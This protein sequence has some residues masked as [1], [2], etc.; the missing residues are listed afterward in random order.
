[1][2]DQTLTTSKLFS[3]HYH[4]NVASNITSTTYN[5]VKLC[6]FRNNGK[7]K[8]YL[9][10]IGI[11]LSFVLFLG[12]VNLAL[13]AG[14]VGRLD[15]RLERDVGKGLDHGELLAVILG[16]LGVAGS[17]QHDHV[18]T[19]LLGSLGLCTNETSRTQ[20]KANV[21]KTTSQPHREPNPQLTGDDVGQE[22]GLLGGG[23]DVLQDRLVAV[24]LGLG[25]D[26]GVV[27]AGQILYQIALL[28]VLEQHLL[29]VHAAARVDVDLATALGPLLQRLRD[30][31]VDATQ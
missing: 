24:L 14:T 2:T 1:M 18:Q 26:L 11:Y 27:V 3:Y 29:G 19:S 17:L 9:V 13:G 15:D 30:V 31:I 4:L 25:A 20:T 21:R 28:A 10:L 12:L 8:K 7:N 6:V 23:L 22:E 5:F 16:Q